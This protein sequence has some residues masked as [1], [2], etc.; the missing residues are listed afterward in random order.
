M[1]LVSIV[2]K[3]ARQEFVAGG[4]G[5]RPTLSQ[6]QLLYEI[7]NGVCHVGKLAEAFGISQPATS[8]MVNTLVKEGLV[9]RV[10]HPMDRRQIDLHLTAKGSEEMET[11]YHRAFTKI[12]KKLSS[13]SATRKNEI[14]KLL[15]ELTDLL[16]ETEK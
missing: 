2:K 11:G 15:G 4:G 5:K 1:D 8:I 10:P 7:Q 6:F 3:L 16:S 12:D 9:E 14:T 13:L